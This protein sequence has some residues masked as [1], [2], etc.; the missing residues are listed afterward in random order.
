MAPRW[1]KKRFYYMA[2][3]LSATDR[4]MLI[5]SEENWVVFQQMTVHKFS[6][7]L[8]ELAAKMNCIDFKNTLG[9]RKK[10]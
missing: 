7:I 3:E 2:D 4:G 1:W 5:A 6:N 9:G 10:P 8:K